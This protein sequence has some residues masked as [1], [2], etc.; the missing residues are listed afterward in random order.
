MGYWDHLH[1]AIVILVA[2]VLVT[3]LLARVYYDRAYLPVT[4]HNPWA[5]LI[6]SLSH[7]ARWNWDKPY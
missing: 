1:V 4:Q 3:S 6:E 7:L 2:T 5:A